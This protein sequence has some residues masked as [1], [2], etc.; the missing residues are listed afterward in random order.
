MTVAPGDRVAPG[1]PIGRCGNSGNT[2]QPHLHL[3]VQSGPDFSNDD[4]ALH[5]FEVAWAQVQ[6]GD[7]VL[8]QHPARRNDVLL[9]GGGAGLPPRAAP[10]GGRGSPVFGIGCP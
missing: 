9:P 8:P 4:P 10:S 5:T 6:R 3:Q 2:S 7:A 1:D